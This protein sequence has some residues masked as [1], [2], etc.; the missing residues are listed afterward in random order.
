MSHEVP[1]PLTDNFVVELDGEHS[2]PI[3]PLTPEHIARLVKIREL[4]IE[5]GLMQRPT[6]QKERQTEGQQ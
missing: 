2:D 6:E 5:A 1:E 3:T 4:Y